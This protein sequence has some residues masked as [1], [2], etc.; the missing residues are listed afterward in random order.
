MKRKK[1][2]VYDEEDFSRVCTALLQLEGHSTDCLVNAKESGSFNEMED[3]GLLIT[4]YPYGTNILNLIKCHDI[5]TLVLSDCINSELLGYLKNIKNLF[6]MIK[7][8]DFGRFLKFVNN[9]MVKE[10]LKN[11]NWKIV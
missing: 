10:D 7:P 9:T 1:I 5:P 3:Y 4:S 2:L 6:C 8:V 11:E